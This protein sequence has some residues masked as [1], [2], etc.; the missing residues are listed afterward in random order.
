MQIGSGFLAAKIDLSYRR[1]NFHVHNSY[2][3]KSFVR[4]K[5]KTLLRGRDSGSYLRIN[6]IQIQRDPFTLPGKRPVL[7]STL[8]FTINV[9]FMAKSRGKYVKLVQAR[10]SNLKEVMLTPAQQPHMSP[11]QLHPIPR[12]ATPD[13]GSRPTSSILPFNPSCVIG[14]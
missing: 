6:R 10:R 7:R 9:T 5:S 3:L 1:S 2:I 11:S 12:N 14:L 13:K 4:R 8:S